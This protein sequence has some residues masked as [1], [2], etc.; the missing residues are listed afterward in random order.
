MSYHDIWNSKQ[1]ICENTDKNT[2]S[3]RNDILE[4]KQL[5]QHTQKQLDIL[6]RNVDELLNER[7]MRNLK[8]DVEELQSDVS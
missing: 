1:K 3:I 2:L 6:T 5:M 8:H 7:D 4:L